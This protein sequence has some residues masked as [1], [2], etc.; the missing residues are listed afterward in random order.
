MRKFLLFT[1]LASF[2]MLTMAQLPNGSTAPDFTLTDLEGNEHNLYSY[3]D[4][5]I[6]VFIDF[7]AV[8]CGSCWIYHESG[9]L[10][11]LYE[12]Y[13]PDGTGEVMVFFIEGDQGTVEQLNG[14]NDSQGDWVTGTQYPIIPT[15]DPNGNQV[16]ADYQI[17][18]WPTLYKICPEGIVEEMMQPSTEAMY[19]AATACPSI[20]A[21]MAFEEGV[22]NYLEGSPATAETMACELSTALT[23]MEE[24]NVTLTVDAPADWS[25]EFELLGTVY[26]E[27]AAVS[28]VDTVSQD[29]SLSYTPGDTPGIGVY[30]LR[31]ESVNNPEYFR[32]LSVNVI[33]G[34]SDL[35]VS[36]ANGLG[37]GSAGD[38]SNWEADYVAGLESANNDEFATTDEQV[39]S[40]FMQEGALSQVNNVYY[41]VG[42]TFPSFTDEL[43]SD[44]SAFLDNGGN[45]FISGQD[46]GWETMDPGGYGTALTQGF[47]TNYLQTEY[48]NDGDATTDT[49]YFVHTGD[50]VFGNVNQVAVVTDFYGYPDGSNAPYM[51]AEQ[52][53]PAT[54]NAATIMQYIKPSPNPMLDPDTIT[55]GVRVETEDYKVVYLGVG[56]EMFADAGIKN[57][58]LQLSHDWFYGLISTDIFEQEMQQMHL[59]Q[60]YPNPANEQT[61]ITIA[62]LDAV[63]LAVYDLS[64]RL[65]HQ[66]AVE[67]GMGQNCIIN[68][69]LREWHLFV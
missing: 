32:E 65:V 14:G 20:Y 24:F 21:A 60:N 64:G 68:S 45:L 8:W 69:T 10:E 16:T 22:S 49:L 54:A 28:L 4:Q 43:V 37:D 38:A 40:G 17:G 6:T 48:L 23:V 7:S 19:A 52:I 9:A 57:K 1:L 34:V 62:G 11:D 31:L 35:I 12:Q 51:Y 36:N 15:V 47:Y 63:D 29:L 2:S 56:I 67:K 59:V 46:I 44:L 58:V 13:G 33:S 42:W 55:G 61:V 66:Q 53:A 5:G 26:T 18:Y 3:L 30:T 25:A 41:N 27:S 50:A 39:F